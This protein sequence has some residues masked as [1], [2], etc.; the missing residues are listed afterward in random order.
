MSGRLIRLVMFAALAVAV[1]LG[2]R[3]AL[4]LLLLWHAALLEV[5]REELFLRQEDQ[6]LSRLR[7]YWRELG[8]R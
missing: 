5:F 1:W 3:V 8:G 6:A 4:L 7:D 2:S